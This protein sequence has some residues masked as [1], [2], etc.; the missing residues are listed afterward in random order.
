MTS[1]PGEHAAGS[2]PD[3][4]LLHGLGSRW[5][6]FTP[7]LPALER[8]HRVLALDLPGFGARADEPLADMSLGGL[9]D[10]VS[11][12]LSRRGIRAPHVVGFSMGGGIA[13]ELARR[14][15]A[16]RV[17]AF[18]PIGFWNEP[19]RRWGRGMLRLLRVA[20]ETFPGPLAR[21][22]RTRPARAALLAVT[23]GRPTRVNP[24][25]AISD[26]H[27]LAASRGFE[28]ARTAFRTQ[29]M[30]PEARRVPA[31]IVWGR[32]DV[33]LWGLT[34]PQRARRAWPHARHLLLGGCGHIPF[35]D[36]P[37][38]TAAAILAAPPSPPARPFASPGLSSTPTPEHTA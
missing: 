14:G 31:T 16:G 20:A 36:A 7:I 30:V 3:L 23:N 25:D 24:D 15:F 26:L 37:D 38:R 33:L 8:E 18:A 6:A 28:P 21:A 12:E 29:G 32:R 34:Q 1:I 11:A 4:V 10:W 17:T 27:A 22:L 13:L 9:A 2:G 19:E 35:S 5:Q